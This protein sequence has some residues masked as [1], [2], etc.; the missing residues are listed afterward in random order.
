MNTKIDRLNLNLV[1]KLGGYSSLPKS[2]SNSVCCR[3]FRK[4]TLIE[5]G[6]DFDESMKYAEDTLLLARFSSVCKS[7][8]LID[9]PVY[10]YY[11]YQRSGSAMKEVDIVQ[12]ALSMIKLAK[13]YKTESIHA[14]EEVAKRMSNAYIRAMQAFCRD[15][16]LYCSDKNSVRD[17]MHLLKSISF[18]PYGVDKGNF[19]IDK[20]QS[21]KND[22][23][24]WMFGLLSIE[25]YFWLCWRACSIIRT[26]GKTFIFN[27]DDFVPVFDK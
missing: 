4:C 2:Y 22:I 7:I 21:I 11:Y 10:Y 25:P 26:R 27:I 5:N 19:R 14:S 17:I 3:W 6:I 16:C 8:L 18:Y 23:M 12:H 9:I 20:R 15:L 13:V 24:N 1:T